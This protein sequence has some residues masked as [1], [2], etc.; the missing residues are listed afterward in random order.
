MGVTLYEHGKY[1]PVRSG[2]SCPVCGMRDGRCSIFYYKDEAEHVSCKYVVSDEPSNLPGWYIHRIGNNPTKFKNIE[3]K[4]ISDIK[5]YIIDKETKELRHQ[6]YTDLKSII[7]SYIPSG[8]YKE[9]KADLTRRGLS[10]GQIEKLGCF[11]VP[12]STHRVPSDNSSYD[13]QLVTYISQ[14]LY[15]TYGDDLLKVPG[16]Q[17]FT[18]NNGD[19]I[20]LKTKIK[21]QK[22]GNLV[23]I[24]GY[25][26]PYV[27]YK[28]Q[29][30]GMQYRLSEAVLDNKGKPI[31][32][33]WLSSFQASSGSPIDYIK[34]TDVVK[35]DILIVGEGALK[36]K[37]ACHKLNL[38][39]MAQAGVTN[40]NNL[41]TDLQMLEIRTRKKYDVVVA[42]DMDKYEIFQIVGGEKI[43]Q[44]LEAEMKLIELL[45]LTGHSVAVAEWDI[46]LGKGIDDALINGA[47][48]TYKRV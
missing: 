28:N 30:S 15:E 43:F 29:I 3:K 34:P 27:S 23:D 31:R 22:T 44:V 7:S 32:Y 13:M 35:E 5:S 33:F 2:V 25:F 36:M 12:K 38:N 46:K 6:V 8:L 9:D 18:G 16:F 26:I 41:I 10:E 19:Y 24:R 45:K 17:K 37:I 42:Y 1:V 20:T 4:Y 47:K 14:K 48:I 21:D 40:Y 11:S 39:G